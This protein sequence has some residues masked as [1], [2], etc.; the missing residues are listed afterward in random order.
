MLFVS[1]VLILF[2]FISAINARS[3]PGHNRTEKVMASLAMAFDGER[4]SETHVSSSP[5]TFDVNS[6]VDG[7]M[8]EIAAL[9]GAHLTSRVLEGDIGPRSGEVVVPYEALFIEGTATPLKST[10]ALLRHIAELMTSTSQTTPLHL[11]LAVQAR[12]HL[13]SAH[14]TRWVSTLAAQV[15]Y[16][17]IPMDQFNVV[18][19]DGPQDIVRFG[20]EVEEGQVVDPEGAL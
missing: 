9:F 18:L 3:I 7:P 20:F 5:H 10:E 12:L 11:K 6:G 13:D 4:E 2:A 17:G 14:A 19:V 8:K 1:V 16:F 15:S